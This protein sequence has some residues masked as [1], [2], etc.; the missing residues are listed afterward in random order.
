MAGARDERV[1]DLFFDDDGTLGDPSEEGQVR[2]R[3]GDLVGFIGGTV[4]SL[5]T[6]T[7]G[8]GIT[9]PQHKALDTLVHDLA[10]SAFVEYGYTGFRITS[11]TVW[12]D[13]TKTTKIREALYSYTFGRVSQI[14]T[15]QFDGAGAPVE[16]L[17]ESITYS[18]ARIDTVTAVLT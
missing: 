2:L 6:G 16:T 13:A 5:T 8:S 4:K 12:T 18:G 10:E 3:G 14:V 11:E 9:E 7:G 17:T 15:V 1:V